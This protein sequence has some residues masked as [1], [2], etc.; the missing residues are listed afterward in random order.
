MSDSFKD[1][2]FFVYSDSSA[3]HPA[4]T[5]HEIDSA[6]ATLVVDDRHYAS[7]A[8]VEWHSHK[9]AQLLYAAAG[10]MRVQV[11][12]GSWIVPPQRAIWVPANVDHR[13]EMITSTTTRSV[14]VDPLACENFKSNVSPIE[15]TSFL[16]E[17]VSEV[18]RLPYDYPLSPRNQALETLLLAEIQSN[19]LGLPYAPTVNDRRLKAIEDALFE[20]H[21]F[22]NSAAGWAKF[23]GCSTRHLTRL[24]EKECGMTFTQWRRALRL[25]EACK[26]FSLGHTI[27]DVAYRTGFQDVSTFSVIFRSGMGETPGSYRRRIKATSV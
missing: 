15:V 6:S 4:A 21:H 19:P 24:L 22:E 8:F 12:T 3:M 9:R 25:V 2:R 20:E 11:E 10:L 16:R 7:G 23:V 14:Y 1:D 18:A 27:K 5:S 26:L 17:L 13:A